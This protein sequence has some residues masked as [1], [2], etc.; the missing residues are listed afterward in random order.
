MAAVASN[1]IRKGD[2]NVGNV[3]GTVLVYSHSWLP[4]QVDG[5]AIRMMAHVSELVK[6]GCK[7]ILVTPDFAPSGEGITPP[8]LQAMPGIVEHITIESQWTPV[9]RKNICMKYSIRNFVDLVKLLRRVRPDLVH[10]TQE[11]TLQVLFAACLVCDVPM[12]CSMHTDV[13]Q[14]AARDDEFSPFARVLG[15]TFGRL[16]TA[17]ATYCVKWGYRNWAL[18]GAGFFCV[19]KE[20]KRFLNLAGVGDKKIFSKQWGPMVD[21]ET[22]RIDLP[23]DKIAEE[24]KRL[25]F[26]IKDAFLM[27]Y[28]G[29]VTAEKDI[30]FLVDALKRAPSNVVLALIGPGSM[31]DDLKKLHG[32]EHRLHCEGGFTNR[33]GVALAL[34]ASDCAVSAST[35][36]TIGLTAME[37]LSCGTPFLAAN[38]QGF[39]EHLEHGKNAR[40]WEPHSNESFDRELKAMMEC[41]GKPGWTREELRATMEWA[42]LNDCTERALEAYAFAKKANLRPLRLMVTLSYLALNYIVGKLFN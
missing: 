4:G 41:A 32:K 12:I 40:L 31:V 2:G 39:A 24:R 11:A 33:E 14:I 25:T 37:A 35:M 29:R 22:F 21:R 20:A 15:R 34:R 28:V 27:V 18:A 10:A 5:V 16:H 30:Q 26:G 38:A 19:S 8:A 42:S 13:V 6:R 3:P 7:V 9:Y 1:S 36:E 17:A 23:E